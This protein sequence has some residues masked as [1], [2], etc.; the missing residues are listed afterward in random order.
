MKKYLQVQL[1]P[2]IM[3]LDFLQFFIFSLDSLKSLGKTRRQ[4][5]FIL[6]D[7]MQNFYQ[8]AMDE[9]VKLVE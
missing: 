8:D 3:F 2:N 1:G 9:L 4:N 6:H 5:Y 7:T